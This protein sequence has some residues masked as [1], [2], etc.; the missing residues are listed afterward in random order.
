MRYLLDTSALLAHHRQESGWEAVQALFEADEAEIIMACI[1][2]TE[3]GRRLR[4]LGAPETVVQETLANYQLLCTEVAPVDAATALAAFAIGCRTPRRLP[5][6]DALIAAVAQAKGAVLVH[7][8]AHMR[9]IP[10]ELLQFNDLGTV[11]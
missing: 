7:R 10:A 5:L 4:D 6:V 3:F 1:S 8:D 9:A 11:S 2:L